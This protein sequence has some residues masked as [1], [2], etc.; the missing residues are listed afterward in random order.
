METPHDDLSAPL[1]AKAT[2]DS[3]APAG[4]QKF[5]LGS[6]DADILAT[7][8][9]DP[10]RQPPSLAASLNLHTLFGESQAAVLDKIFQVIVH[11]VRQHDAELAKQDKRLLDVVDS[12][13]ASAKKHAMLEEIVAQNHT[14][15]EKSIDALKK[16]TQTIPDELRKRDE[17]HAAEAKRVQDQLGAQRERIDVVDR[18]IPLAAEEV[19]DKVKHYEKKVLALEQLCCI[20]ADA[21]PVGDRIEQLEARVADL[22]KA[23]ADSRR[24]AEQVEVALKDELAKTAQQARAAMP[25][26]SEITELR[27][28][29]EKSSN[30]ATAAK[31]LA[32]GVADKMEAELGRK[33]AGNVDRDAASVAGSGD[34][35]NQKLRS[36]E[37][38]LAD[39]ENRRKIDKKTTDSLEKNIKQTSSK[40]SGLEAQLD[41]IRADLD[42]I[43]SRPP[44]STNSTNHAP[45]DGS[46]GRA[47]PYFDSLATTVMVHSQKISQLLERT[48]GG[49]FGGSSSF[50]N[51]GSFGQELLSLRSTIEHLPALQRQLADVLH[52]ID[53]LHERVD[54]K[55]D[56]ANLA[57]LAA[58]VNQLLSGRLGPSGRASPALSHKGLQQLSPLPNSKCILC[59]DLTDKAA[60]T[61]Q[62]ANVLIKGS[63]APTHPTSTSMFSGASTIRGSGARPRSVSS[64]GRANDMTSTQ[65]SSLMHHQRTPL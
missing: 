34:E 8:I 13:A 11:K 36:V 32:Q 55:A 54:G 62:W 42:T 7:S 53:V 15:H 20:K 28:A 37:E 16:V 58:H 1:T 30:T 24:Q 3:E 5:N 6:L 4:A 17:L 44:A 26:A 48:N 23:L 39:D 19:A 47:G 35:W 60:T 40:V 61:D 65:M 41:S 21:V 29:V 64:F 31:D 57:H 18:K 51:S 10:N 22:V 25:V 59:G 45:A 9:W 43:I 27:A 50:G 46:F 14:D 49:S 12:N 2:P 33:T 63:A 38:R 56:Q 52:E